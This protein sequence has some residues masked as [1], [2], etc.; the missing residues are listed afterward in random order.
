MSNEGQNKFTELYNKFTDDIKINS[1]I[2]TMVNKF[3]EFIENPILHEDEKS[4]SSAACTGNTLVYK[5]SIPIIFN[6]FMH[7][8]NNSFHI[9]NSMMHSL[10]I[11]GLNSVNLYYVRGLYI[12]VVTLVNI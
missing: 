3:K 11:S 9:L 2:N 1:I 8:R 7:N 12:I 10:N 6:E 5:L 4:F